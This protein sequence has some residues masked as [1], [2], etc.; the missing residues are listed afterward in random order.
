MLRAPTPE[1]PQSNAPSVTDRVDWID[2]ARGLAIVLVIIGHAMEPTFYHRPDHNF[3]SLGFQTWRLIYSMHLP[4][5]FMIAGLV[6][7]PQN[8][9]SSSPVRTPVFLVA[10]AFVWHLVGV[11]V[12]ALTTVLQKSSVL[13]LTQLPAIAL[14]PFILGTGFSLA[15]LWFL[16]TL[17]SVEMIWS[18][19]R[20]RPAVLTAVATG[21]S[22]LA[23]NAPQSMAN[24]W[25]FKS[26]GPALTF[27]ALGH[28]F[29]IAPKRWFIWTL[30]LSTCT[31][32][33][34]AAAN[35]G[36]ILPTGAV[37]EIEG[38]NGHFGVFMAIGRYGFY[39]Y[40]LIAAATGGLVILGLGTI[41]SR[42]PL[43][44]FWVWAGRSS[45]E[46]YLVNAVVFTVLNPLLR[47]SAL[48]GND[49]RLIPVLAVVAVLSHALLAKAL[50]PT[51]ARSKSLAG[52][53]AA[54]LARPLRPSLSRSRRVG[55]DME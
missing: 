29:R 1:A 3:S 13:V 7:K 6:K 5:L 54:K 33:A 11:V 20:G 45:L 12:V 8:Q 21:L 43:A 44:R 38:F 42:G 48:S 53:L 27:Y 41:L 28:A 36:C 55:L 22:L 15:P 26:L 51:I 39:P 24:F 47:M 25:G 4:A 37:C 23:I 18:R 14:R 35:H 30:G 46:L 40:F 50:I 31:W 17:A 52:H 9:V 2:A 32:I 19:L 16:L 34:A 49:L 10:L